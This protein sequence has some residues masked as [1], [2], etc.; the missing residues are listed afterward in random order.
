MRGYDR[1]LR[2]EKA[3]LSDDGYNEIEVWAELA[4]VPARY[5][6]SAGKEAREQLGREAFLTASF[7]IPWSPTLSKMAPDGYQLRFPPDPAGQL[8]D[9]KSAVEI[10]RHKQIEII[11]LA[12]IERAP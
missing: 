5:I 6:P 10:G 12:R 11:A 4:T 8:W 1:Q 7:R 9:I 3:T 2:V